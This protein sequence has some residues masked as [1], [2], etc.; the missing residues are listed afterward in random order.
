MTEFRQTEGPDLSE[1]PC[2]E[3]GRVGQLR[4]ELV[5]GLQVCPIGTWSLAGR[6]MK[7]CALETNI[8]HV[9]CDCGF[10]K[11]PSR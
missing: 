7:T 3:C 6:Q 1:L 9:V 10:K 8:P 2:P 4:V 5:R 11:A